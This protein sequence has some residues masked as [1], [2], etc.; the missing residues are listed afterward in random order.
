[1]SLLIALRHQ[2]RLTPFL[3]LLILLFLITT[4][5]FPSSSSSLPLSSSASPNPPARRP[6]TLPGK[7]PLPSQVVTGSIT[8]QSVLETIS[9]SIA[10]RAHALDAPKLA[11]ELGINV[12]KELTLERYAENLRETWLE[13]FE[14]PSRAEGGVYPLLDQVLSRLSVL[15]GGLGAAEEEVPKYIYTTDLLSPEE[16]PE[17]FKSWTTQN[18]EWT[19]MFVS[20]EEIDAWLEKS[21]GEG[22][23]GEGGERDE[24]QTVAVVKEMLELK[25]KWGVVRADLFRYLVLLLNGGV[26]T[27]TDTASVLPISQ[28][29]KDPTTTSP[30]PLLTALPHLLAIS[31]PSSPAD[32]FPSA[33]SPPALLVSLEV[34]APNSGVDWKSESF[35]RGIQVVQWTIMA[36][37]GHPVLLDVIGHGLRRAREVRDMERDGREEVSDKDANILEWSGPGAFTDAVFRY[38]LVR[39]GFHPEQVSG[40]K[41]PLRVGDVL[42]MPPN[43]FRADASEGF[44]GDHRVVWHG[45]FGRWKHDN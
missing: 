40:I 21:L 14:P 16:L 31:S 9:Q 5:L 23:V 2:N 35:A 36:K 32:L 34:D 13:F 15:P 4:H 37:R 26:Y 18:P 41:Q 25:S 11:R 45:F 8:F 1:M 44:Q 3:L 7:S 12:G 10:D 27:D 20:D 6:I 30:H 43:S 33:D 19:T 17:Q 24:A 38:L 42:I 29:G 22:P 39:Y 28:W